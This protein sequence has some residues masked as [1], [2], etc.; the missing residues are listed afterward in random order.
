MLQQSRNAATHRSISVNIRN[1][2]GDKEL[3][4][5]HGY[6]NSTLAFDPTSLV[7]SMCTS[8]APHAKTWP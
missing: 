1:F 3:S 7:G 5:A 4:T 2:D 6:K 8:D